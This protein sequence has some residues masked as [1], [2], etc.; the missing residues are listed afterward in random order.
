MEKAPNDSLPASEDIL[1]LILDHLK[2]ITYPDI[3]QPPEQMSLENPVGWG[4]RVY[5]YAALR[6][7]TALL[8]GMLS[9]FDSGNSPA[10]RI[11]ARSAYEVGAH[12][13]YVK[14]HLKQHID[15]KDFA[16]AWKFLTPIATASRYISE[17]NPEENDLFPLPAHISKVVNCF[18]EVTPQDDDYSYLSEF[19]HPNAMAFLQHYRRIN[20]TTIRFQSSTVHGFLGS[21]VT[22]STQGIAAI[23]DLLGLANERDVREPLH[24]LIRKIVDLA[25]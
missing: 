2:P 14:K 8:D 10:A 21:I 9:L 5:S 24:K 18:R 19:I 20:P 7:L 23:Y 6:H 4:A 25:R 22:A 3:V 17:Q 16:A 15:K 12:A 1:R 13:Y 11:V